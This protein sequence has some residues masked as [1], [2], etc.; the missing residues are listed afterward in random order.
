ML[1]C[2]TSF[3]CSCAGGPR[4]SVSLSCGCVFPAA[5]CCSSPEQQWCPLLPPQTLSDSASVKGTCWLSLPVWGEGGRGEREGERGGEGG[6]RWERERGGGGVGEREREKE[7]REGGEIRGKG[8]GDKRRKITG[9]LLSRNCW[10]LLHSVHLPAVY[11][12]H[13]K[14]PCKTCRLWIFEP[15]LSKH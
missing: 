2:L 4:M 12:P 6:G 9:Y 3:L 8:E 7:G 10:V 1:K 11:I 13:T 15:L 14:M 5:C